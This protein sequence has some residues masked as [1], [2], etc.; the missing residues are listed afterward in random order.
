MRPCCK[1]LPQRLTEYISTTNNT[2]T[3]IGRLYEQ[4][5]QQL[6]QISVVEDILKQHLWNLRPF[7]YLNIN[8]LRTL[9]IPVAV[10]D[11]PRLP[12]VVLSHA[13]PPEVRGEAEEN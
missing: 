11:L 5:A 2:N 13:S 3:S 1:E 4:N 12:A 6:R 9:G 8:C 10:V 7:C